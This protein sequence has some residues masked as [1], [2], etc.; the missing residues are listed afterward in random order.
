MIRVTIEQSINHAKLTAAY[1][2]QLVAGGV[3]LEQAA[4]MSQYYS[5]VVA[6]GKDQDPPDNDEPWRT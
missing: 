5:T 4:S 1:F 6:F 3:P 2:T